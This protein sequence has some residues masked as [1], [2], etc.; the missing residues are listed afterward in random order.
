MWVLY[1][2]DHKKMLNCQVSNQITKQKHKI[3]K[4]SPCGNR[5]ISVNLNLIILE[6]PT[7]ITHG[8]SISML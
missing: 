5:I 4:S 2:K 1:E 8:N 7:L 3:I 6:I